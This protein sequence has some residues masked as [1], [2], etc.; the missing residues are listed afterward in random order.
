MF[1]TK[2][3]I[4]RRTFLRGA[5]VTFALPLARFD[6]A[7][8]DRCWP[9]RRP[10]RSRAS[11]R[12][13]FRTE[14][15]RAITCP[16]DSSCRPRRP[17][18]VRSPSCRSP[19]SRSNRAVKQLVLLNGLHSRS[20]EPPAGQ[21]PADHWV[22]AAYLCANKPK[23]HGRRRHLRGHDDRSDDR[24][25]DRPGQPDAV[26]AARGRGPGR[27]LEQLR[28]RLQLRVH[29]HHLL[30]VADDAAAD[31]AEPAGRLRADVRR[32]QHRRGARRAPGPRSKHSGLTDGQP[33]PPAHQHQRR[34]QGAARRVHRGRARNRTATS[35]RHEGGRSM[36][37]PTSTV[38]VGVPQSF[39]EHIKLQFDLLALAF[40]ATSPASAR[41]CLRAT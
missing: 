33:V 35:D 27:Q 15:R 31:G 24:A 2:K 8:R 23:K 34:R 25:E 4:P 37:R 36:R 12:C 18:A 20:A 17:A 19:T 14:W 32:R 21:S 10:R 16:L 11:S 3:H 40:Q 13:S 29:E 28:R 22:A 41:C 26:D 7:G 5:G 39:D 30:V 38:P 6:G 9:R 1:I